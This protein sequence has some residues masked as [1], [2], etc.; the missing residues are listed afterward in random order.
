MT[1]N[2]IRRLSRDDERRREGFASKAKYST[3]VRLR[4]ESGADATNE[5]NGGRGRVWSHCERARCLPQD[6]ACRNAGQL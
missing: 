1:G 2:W 4:G 6:V 5:A 3:T